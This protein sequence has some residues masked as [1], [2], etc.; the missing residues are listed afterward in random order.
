MLLETLNAVCAAPQDATLKVIPK[1]PMESAITAME[2]ST[3]TVKLWRMCHPL[4][5]PRE[6]ARV[7]SDLKLV[8]TYQN[9]DH[10]L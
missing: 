6:I 5:V 8:R 3:P 1:S 2:R 7:V 9:E 10:K 4:N